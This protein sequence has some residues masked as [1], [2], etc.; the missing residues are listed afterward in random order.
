MT[1]IN[2]G[3]EFHLKRLQRDLEAKYDEIVDFSQLRMSRATTITSLSNDAEFSLSQWGA[4]TLCT[5]LKVPYEYYLKCD[6]E[7]K[8]YNI[9]SWLEQIEKDNDVMLRLR[10]QNGNLSQIRGIVSTKYSKINNLTVAQAAHDYFELHN[11]RYSIDFF[12]ED[13]DNLNMRLCMEDK[14]T[15]IGRTPD[16]KDDIHKVAVHIRNSEVGR[17]GVQVIPMVYRLVCT[18]GLMA[19]TATGKVYNQRHIYIGEEQLQEDVV[20]AIAGAVEKSDATIKILEKAKTITVQNPYQ[21]IEKIAKRNKY[22]E[23]FTKA[24]KEAYENENDGKLFYLVQAFTDAAKALP[25]DSRLKVEKEAA[26]LLQ[27]AV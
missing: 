13:G 22:S 20:A 26:K 4:Q 25:D 7:Q 19:W 21:E 24:I 6:K 10:K 5:K 14:V 18:N 15:Q 23:K 3:L 17:A 1:K 9:N 12:H 8:Q 16:G 27:L 2:N 11:E